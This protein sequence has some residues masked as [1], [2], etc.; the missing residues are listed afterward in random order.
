MAL[1][2]HVFCQDRRPVSAAEI[3]GFISEG[4]YF[5]RPA[6]I[7]RVPLSAGQDDDLAWSEMLIVYAAGRRPVVLQREG[8]M[9]EL[10]REAAEAIGELETGNAMASRRRLL[11]DLEQARQLFAI[12][13]DDRNLTEDCWEMV[14]GLQS[15]IARERKGVIYVAGEGLYDADLQRVLST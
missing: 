13:L 11:S 6:E 5:A 14:D 3:A 4:C 1:V 8:R 12:E 15:W 7:G 2:I 10:A 9:E